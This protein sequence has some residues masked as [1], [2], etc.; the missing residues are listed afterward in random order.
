MLVLPIFRLLFQ[1]VHILIGALPLKY[2]CHSNHL[3]WKKSSVV[4]A[5]AQVVDAGPP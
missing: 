2:T 3:L 5:E 1:P 4:A